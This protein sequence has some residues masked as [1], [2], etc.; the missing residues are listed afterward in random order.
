M[1]SHEKQRHDFNANPVLTPAER[2]ALEELGNRLGIP[3]LAT[4]FTEA[5]KRT[6]GVNSDYPYWPRLEKC[7][8]VNGNHSEELVL[9][10]HIEPSFLP[11]YNRSLRLCFSFRECRDNQYREVFEVSYWQEPPQG[12]FAYSPDHRGHFKEGT[13]VL[14]HTELTAGHKIMEDVKSGLI[15]RN[16]PFIINSP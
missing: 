13:L 9:Y 11:Q 16:Q 1:D 5:A 3:D 15:K 7:R 14:P 10:G 4:A 6:A 8:S 12:L 2:H